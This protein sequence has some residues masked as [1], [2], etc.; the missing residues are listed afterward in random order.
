M[1][2]RKYIKMTLIE[3]QTDEQRLLSAAA[4]EFRERITAGYFPAQLEKEIKKKYAEIGESARV[5]VRSS[6]TIVKSTN[7]NPRF[8][9][10]I[11]QLKPACI[12]SKMS[13]LN[14]FL[15]SC[16]GIPHSLS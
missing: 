3:K 6:T 15:S 12:H 4:G 14:S 5:A 9:R 8:F 7:L 16:T 2:L 1:I 13:I 11:A 10:I